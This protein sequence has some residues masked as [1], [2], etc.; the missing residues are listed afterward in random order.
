MSALPL[1]RAHGLYPLCVSLTDQCA[2]PW[3]TQSK[4]AK[5][6]KQPPATKAN[7]RAKLSKI[8]SLLRVDLGMRLDRIRMSFGVMTTGQERGKTDA[9]YMSKPTLAEEGERVQEPNEGV[10]GDE[11]ALVGGADVAD[12]GDVGLVHLVCDRE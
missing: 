8:F 9:L 1:C 4:M 11:E 6:V 12:E 5:K 7:R 2:C 10:H 3:F